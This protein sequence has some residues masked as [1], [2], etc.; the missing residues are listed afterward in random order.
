MRLILETW[1]YLFVIWTHFSELLIAI[2]MLLFKKKMPKCCLPK[3]SH[4][5]LIS[6]CYPV[7]IWNVCQPLR[8]LI[9]IF[10]S[11][12]RGC[13]F[14]FTWMADIKGN[15][16]RAISFFWYL[17][18][19]SWHWNVFCFIGPLYGESTDRQWAVD[20][21]FH[22]PIFVYLNRPLNNQWSCQ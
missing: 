10:M 3:C 11:P 12:T 6:M 16:M 7:S 14:Y 2:Q 9:G 21:K 13:Q 1:R 19:M 5:D 15:L 22:V 17:L 18:T 20:A 4:F 8:I